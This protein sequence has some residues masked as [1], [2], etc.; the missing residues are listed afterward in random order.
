VS[1]TALLDPGS[2]ALSNLTSR[3]NKEGLKENFKVALNALVDYCDSKG[4]TAALGGVLG[5]AAG[6]AIGSGKIG[7]AVLGAAAGPAGAVIGIGA[8]MYLCIMTV[9]WNTNEVTVRTIKERAV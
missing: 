8:A 3:L 5:T 4:I 7:G 1:F 2:G 6:V 9:Y